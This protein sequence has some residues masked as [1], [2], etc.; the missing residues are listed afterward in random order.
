VGQGA[1]KVAGMVEKL[2]RQAMQGRHEKAAEAS[3]PVLAKLEGELMK[4]L[5]VRA[6]AIG[7]VVAG[8]AE[9][10]KK[11]LDEHV[12]EI[13]AAGESLFEQAEER[14]GQRVRDIRTEAGAGLDAA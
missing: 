1:N 7:R 10:I 3:G 13:C 2:L 11:S 6:A 14:I 4:D 5:K 9:E 12:N 8:K